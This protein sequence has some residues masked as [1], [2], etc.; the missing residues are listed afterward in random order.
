[1][2]STSLFWRAVGGG[3]DCCA[4]GWLELTSGVG[5]GAEA[6]LLDGGEA[7]AAGWLAA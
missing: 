7:D 2:S 6:T 4:E 5:G 3:A 1:M